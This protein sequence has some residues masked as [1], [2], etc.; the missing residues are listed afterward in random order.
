LA[1]VWSFRP[2]PEVDR[3]KVYPPLLALKEPLTVKAYYFADG[4]TVGIS[5]T[6]NEQ[7]VLQFCFPSDYRDLGYSRLFVGALY[8]HDQPVT[9]ISPAEP[10]AEYLKQLLRARSDDPN[11]ADA[12]SCLNGRLH[13]HWKVIKHN[14]VDGKRPKISV[15]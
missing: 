1:V 9:E 13:E 7:N 5:I 3:A 11:A 12:V 2:Y 10:T 8:K 15:D 6:D 4:G 14:F